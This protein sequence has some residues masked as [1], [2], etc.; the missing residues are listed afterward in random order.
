MLGSIK[1][2]IS[3]VLIKSK[4]LLESA[5]ILKSSLSKYRLN[6]PS[7]D[8]FTGVARELSYYK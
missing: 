3:L 8:R 4:W 6:R 1:P 7:F 5:E 2:G